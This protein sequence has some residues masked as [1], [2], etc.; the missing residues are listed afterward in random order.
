ML[1]EPALLL[2]KA[3]LRTL[4]ALLGLLLQLGLP[5]LGLF[6]PIRLLLRLPLHGF[7]SRLCGRFGGAGFG[8]RFGG[9]GLCRRGRCGRCRFLRLDNRGTPCF[10][11]GRLLL[12]D[13]CLA[14]PSDL[15]LCLFCHLA[16]LSANQRISWLLV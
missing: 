7:L 4:L 9:A 2:G 5:L 16:Y 11:S 1:L 10:R 13:L 12:P 15:L 8:G 3:V 14:A 6:R